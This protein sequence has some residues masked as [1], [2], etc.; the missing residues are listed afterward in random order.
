MKKL[1]DDVELN[2]ICHVI[3]LSIFLSKDKKRSRLSDI[4]KIVESRLKR[5]LDE[6]TWQEALQILMREGLINATT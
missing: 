5:S 3:L 4:R 2:Y 1:C 6:D